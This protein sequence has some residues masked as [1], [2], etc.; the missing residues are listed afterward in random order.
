VSSDATTAV[1]QYDNGDEKSVQKAALQP[2]NRGALVRAGF[3]DDLTLLDNLA[4]PLILHCLRERFKKQ[5]IYTSIGTITISINPYQ[6]LPLYTPDVRRTYTSRGDGETMPPHVYNNAHEA[7]TGLTEFGKNQSIIISGESGAGKTE[8]TKQ[9]LLYLSEVATSVGDIDKKVQEASPLLEAFGNAKTV[10]NDN[11]SRFGKYLQISFD[12]AHAICGS[13]TIQYLLEKIRVVNPSAQERNYHI[14]YQLAGHAPAEIKQKHG[15]SDVSAYKYLT[16]GGCVKCKCDDAKDYNEVHAALKS[17]NFSAAAVSDMFS[18]L[19]AILALGNI[20]F[21]GGDKATMADDQWLGIVSA[22][23]RV[24]TASLRK[25]LLVRELRIRGQSSMDVNLS[26]VAASDTRDALAKFI[27]GAMFGW[28][29]DEVN[30]SMVRAGGRKT[31][32]TIGCLDI[33]GF[34]IFEHNSFEQLCINF[35][36]EMLQQHFNKYTFKLEE[37]MYTAEGITFA[38]VDFIDNQPMLDL[39]QKKPNGVLPLLDEELRMPQG[40]DE[41]FLQKLTFS[42][43]DS[44]VYSSSI[45]QKGGFRIRHYAGEVTYQSSGFLEKNRDTLT[46]DLVEMVATSQLPLM[47]QLFPECSANGV[48]RKASLGKQFQ[49][50]LNELMHELNSTQPH[51]VRCIKPNPDKS[52]SGFVPRMVY[53][54]LLFSGVFETV[55]I[56]KQGFPFRLTHADFVER[57]ACIVAGNSGAGV[58][59]CQQVCAHLKLNTVNFQVGATRILYRSDEHRKLELERNIV[60][61]SKDV[62]EELQ[63]LVRRGA[64]V[65]TLSK[66]EREKYFELLAAVV[67]DANDF[68][69][70]SSASEAA[71]VLLDKFI[72]ERIDPETKRQLAAGIAALDRAALERA[73]ATADEQGYCT[74]DCV[75]ARQLLAKLEEGEELIANGIALFD[76][77]L[78][79]QGINFCDALGYKTPAVE[80]ARRIIQSLMELERECQAVLTGSVEVSENSVRA[81]LAK[82]ERE[83]PGCRSHSLD[84]LQKLLIAICGIDDK[85]AAAL[86]AAAPCKG[87]LERIFDEARSFNYVSGP[88]LT[89]LHQTI[90]ALAAVD[91]RCQAALVSQQQADLQAV[92]GEAESL[93]YES[94][95]VKQVQ[96][97]LQMISEIDVH[98]RTAIDS[99]D[100]EALGTAIQSAEN[101]GYNSVHVQR[102]R[103]M[104]TQLRA[105]H[106]EVSR[107][108]ELAVNELNERELMAAVHQA[109]ELNCVDDNVMR[110]MDTM[111]KITSINRQA[112]DAVHGNNIEMMKAVV[113]EAMQLG[114]NSSTLENIRGKTFG[115]AQ[116]E[117]LMQAGCAQMNHNMLAQASQVAAELRLTSPIIEEGRQMYQRMQNL[118]DMLVCC[119]QLQQPSPQAVQQCDTALN[120]AR[121]MNFSP[122]PQCRNV[123]EHRVFLDNSPESRLRRRIEADL[124]SLRFHEEHCRALVKAA[125]LINFKSDDMVLLRQ[126]VGANYGEFLQFQFQRVQPTGDIEHLARINARIVKLQLQSI[127]DI[128]ISCSACPLLRQAEQWKKISKKGAPGIFQ[129]QGDVIATSLTVQCDATALKKKAKAVFKAILVFMDQGVGE[130]KEVKTQVKIQR[131]IEAQTEALCLALSD[132]SST[133]A[134]RD[135]WFLQLVK[136]INQKA[137][138]KTQKA[139]QMMA[140]SLTLFLPSAT[141]TMHLSHF[142][143]KNAAEDPFK[144]LEL[145]EHGKLLQVEKP[146]PA[147]AALLLR[148]LTM[149]L[150]EK[151]DKVSDAVVAKNAP[152]KEL[153]DLIV[154]CG[155][156]LNGVVADGVR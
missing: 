151:A 68:R 123:Q 136:Q 32:T 24:P 93:G 42:Q 21:P 11:S 114:Y 80:D 117:E 83:V 41:K 77:L 154:E 109:K 6:S 107:R 94:A 150:R 89:Q 57:Y 127:P 62:E 39:L 145:L 16:K 148:D 56:R 74:N 81:A 99:R 20:A 140:L 9:C 31:P 129:A 96:Q 38:H 115:I 53:D 76:P 66:D 43:K 111:A 49:K 54:Q 55:A 28:I 35:T 13:F 69:M 65:Q 130:T 1:V 92:L 14:F 143:N 25:A 67:R 90:E 106:M 146:V 139:W 52:A 59:A 87:E 64:A 132:V 121:Q 2:L 73:L 33:F 103:E 91:M 10:R 134:L 40:S 63:E 149:V 48:D 30:A 79:Q 82:I 110:A 61:K 85:V 120:M 36:N 126:K 3:V 75:R 44:A 12:E 58:A 46:V 37:I 15:L 116:C 70:K 8:A 95:E 122:Q 18:I 155:G 131:K 78:L 156:N 4:S 29:V 113:S 124:Q 88:T 50:Q 22:Q 27:Y 97:M 147:P 133:K 104:L 100:I 60:I 71:R 144:C 45:K 112:R 72:E 137:S 98:A 23:L 34:E 142:L 135:E 119:S 138:P 102:A 153:L 86:G 152:W 128:A 5:K 125:D 26:A 47:R 105:L 108:C 101:V 19:S 118:Y 7:F 84:Q 141:L 17:L 51:Y